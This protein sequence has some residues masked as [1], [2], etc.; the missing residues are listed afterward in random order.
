MIILYVLQTAAPEATVEDDEDD[1]DDDG[2]GLDE[3]NINTI[4]QNVHCSRGKAIKA[5]RKVGEN[6]LIDAIM[7]RLLVWCWC[8]YLYAS[9]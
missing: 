7:V 9:S 1:D 4:M 5:L 2:A 3:S 8:A 6:N